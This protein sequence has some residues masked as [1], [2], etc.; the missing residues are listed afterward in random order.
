MVSSET[1][2]L[3]GTEE[4]K[5]R[6]PGPWMRY[7]H[8]LAFVGLA[9]ATW[10]MS[11]FLLSFSGM[12]MPEL[13]FS[14]LEVDEEGFWEEIEPSRTLSWTRC[15]DVFECA[16]L[17]VPMDWLE[18]KNA[19]H[20][21]LA[22]IRKN[23]TSTKDYKGPLFVNPGG[24]GGSG[25]SMVKTYGEFFQTAAGENHDI[26]S[27]DPRGVGA[28][29]PQLHCF[30]GP[31]EE[32][33]ASIQ[34]LGLIDAHP[35]LIYDK[36]AASSLA[37]QNCEANIGDIA[38]FV[39]TASVARDM[40]EILDQTG[41][42]KLRYWGLSY[43]TVLGGT[44]A[45]LFP[46]RVERMIVDG[47]VDYAEW[48]NSSGIHY[49]EDTDKGLSAFYEHCS[50][51]GP[52][53][54]ALYAP[55]PSTVAT[56]VESLLARLRITPLLIPANSSHPAVVPEVKEA[57]IVT[58]SDVKNALILSLYQPILFFPSLAT[59]LQS[60]I[61]GD[62]RPFLEIAYA[63]GYKPLPFSCTCGASTPSN[64][65]CGAAPGYPLAARGNGDADRFVR[66]SEGA[67]ETSLESYERYAAQVAKLSP[68]GGSVMFD[69][70][71]VCAGWTTKTRWDFRV[72]RETR[73]AH[74]ILFVGN[75]ADNITPLGSAVR[76]ARLFPGS[77]VL[78]QN[79][80][81]HCSTSTPSRCTFR[82]RMAYFQ[83]GTLPANGTVCEPDFLPFDPDAHIA[84]LGEGGKEERAM[85]EL[86]FLGVK[87][88]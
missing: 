10:M 88:W 17:K 3:L 6:N 31:Q 78:V 85:R 64:P 20:F 30:K 33:I 19:S 22:V 5:S 29:T 23:A 47:V 32:R 14:E 79:S 26:I 61:S 56:T 4:R 74:P 7:R 52:S 59:A 34:S 40:L 24:P 44:F 12:G 2:P 63:R 15:Y 50:R 55:T 42:E 18:P 71:L 80:Y 73:T 69:T 86:M 1:E 46:D 83:D 51:S 13:P 39:G 82:A 70:K 28:T 67:A 21:T 35:G 54:C 84:A 75:Y 58:Y 11:V 76:N 49:C 36:F 57:A 48:Y 9:V 87:G 37:S 25:V 81:G 68:A 41:H 60:L 45:A 77:S 53:N 62:G 8:P 72:P 66:C 27:F 65:G 43:G 38:R 16:R